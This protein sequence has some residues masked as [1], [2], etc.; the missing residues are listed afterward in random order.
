[1]EKNYAFCPQD[2]EFIGGVFE[3]LK[4]ISSQGFELFVITNQSG[5]AR[6]YYTQKDFLC[7]S[8]FMIAKFLEQGICIKEICHCPHKPEDNCLCRKPKPKMILDLQKKYGIDLASSWLVGD[9]ESDIEAGINAGVKTKIL[10]RS[11]HKIDEK[12]T[13]ADFVCNRLLDVVNL[14]KEE[15]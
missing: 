8:E 11:G 9:K 6:G 7:L 12:N 5:I 13:K 15:K 1:M 10:V 4:F 2:L 14:I 3:A